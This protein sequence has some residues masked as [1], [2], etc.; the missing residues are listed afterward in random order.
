[1]ELRD[2]AIEVRLP[3]VFGR[4]GVLLDYAARKASL[5]PR[6]LGKWGGIIP[7]SEQ[8]LYVSR[9]SRKALLH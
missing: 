1:M 4:P 6:V 2:A 9:P 3:G 8:G 5:A 7:R